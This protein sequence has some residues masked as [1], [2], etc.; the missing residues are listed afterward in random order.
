MANIWE[1]D[2]DSMREGT[3]MATPLGE[4]S[5]SGPQRVRFG[6]YQLD[7]TG[8]VLT[9]QGKT[10]RL[11]PQPMRVLVELVRRAGSIVTRDEL[12][13][14]VWGGRFVEFDQSLNFCI[15]QIRS[16][17]GDEAE[18][19]TFVETVPRR[20]Y[21]FVMAV[22]GVPIGEVGPGTV[23]ARSG[24]RWWYLV[25]SSLVL[26]AVILPLATR[27]HQARAILDDPAGADEVDAA[28]LSPQARVEFLT[29]LRWLRTRTGA[30]YQRAAEHLDAV[31]AADP[32][33]VPARVR[34]AEARLWEGRTNEARRELDAILADHPADARAHTLRGALA[35]FRDW[36]FGLARRHLVQGVELAPSSSIANH[37]AAYYHLLAHDTALA[38]SRIE[39]A[40]ELDPVS[41][42]LQGDAGLIFYWLRGYSHS[43]DLCRRGFEAEPTSRQAAY[44]LFLALAA[45]GRRDS[46]PVVARQ[47]ATMDSAPAD[48]LAGLERGPVGLDQYF[49]WEAERLT[50]LP[51]DGQGT[52]LALARIHMLRGKPRA[53]VE[54][55]AA[56]WDRHSNSSIFLGVEP[57]LDPVRGDTT[58]RR[59]ARELRRRDSLDGRQG[60]ADTTGTTR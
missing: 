16:V 5:M 21:R 9:R 23:R 28:Q 20:G 1:V 30:G 25:L 10:V 56:G 35:L 50:R 4:P 13:D 53:A 8:G 14:A 38:R 60:S 6:D 17:L 26:V 59:L 46:L 18:R 11:Q 19:P 45:S 15:R 58:M 29:A 41:P 36:D 2:E 44:C 27:K 33:F 42:A 22:E 57:L 37:Y 52:A 51:D 3:G 24:Q 49:D 47:L 55:L 39:R 43:R 48:V 12:R 54:A 32:G 7:L 31:L 34:R 40:L